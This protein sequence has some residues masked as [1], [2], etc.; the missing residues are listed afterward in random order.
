MATEGR[1]W[2]RLLDQVELQRQLQA[3]QLAGMDSELSALSIEFNEL[4][5]ASENSG[6]YDRLC[7]PFLLRRLDRLRREIARL[8]A[9]RST[10]LEQ[11]RS[12]DARSRVVETKLSEARTWEERQAQQRS[13]EDATLLRLV[14]E[15]SSLAQEN[16]PKS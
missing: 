15:A 6:P 13:I 10:K 9:S 11:I 16:K 3:R 1:D 2:R 14:A 4:L 8:T 7:S 12:A 5:V